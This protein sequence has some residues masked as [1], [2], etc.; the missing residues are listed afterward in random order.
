[1]FYPEDQFKTYWDLFI[2]F[3][4]L[5]SCLITPWRIA[6][7]ELEEPMGWFLVNV[8]VDSLF[9]IDILVIFN[10]AYYDDEF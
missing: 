4:L 6:F 1:M 2:T 9:G 7:G 5:I 3:I 8:I 10:S